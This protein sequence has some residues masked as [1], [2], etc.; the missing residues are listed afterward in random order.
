MTWKAR[1]QRATE[2]TQKDTKI[3]T[4]IDRSPSASLLLKPKH[5]DQ[6]EQAK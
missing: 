6:G 5:N 1:S 4:I 2:S 3:H